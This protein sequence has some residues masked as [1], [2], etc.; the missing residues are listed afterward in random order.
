MKWLTNE[1]VANLQRI[2]EEPEL[3]A[4]RY[5]LVSVIGRGGMGVV[6]EAEDLA[7]E[8]RVALK[9]LSIETD[10][11]DA[12]QRLE[13]EARII[14]RLEHPGIVPIH[15]VGRLAD[16]RIY[17]AMKRV[18]GDRLDTYAR[19][20]RNRADLLR[21][22]LRICETVAFAHANGV[23]HR[24]LKPS[25]VMI[26][27]YGAV[28]VMDWGLA[29]AGGQRDDAG[30][31]AGTPGYM[32]PEQ[33][34]GDVEAIDAATDVFALG[35]IL[36]FLTDAP[37]SGVPKALLAIRQ[38]AMSE[39]KDDRYRSA[40]ELA[41]DVTHFLDGEPVAAYRESLAERGARLLRKH[42][43]LASLIAAYLIMRVIVFFWLRR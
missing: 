13:G 4:N 22:F 21:L 24:D 10:W 36:R 38:K 32:S 30:T 34:G 6:Y 35:A 26:G 37:G 11:P 12:T 8:R 20:P 29:L 39:A 1:T 18:R 23:V 19:V 42:G 14:A 2:A 9:V 27:D 33:T 28:L 25:N 5:R 16:G 7:L 31:V 41:D 3:D 17:Y 43:A 15:D 40:G